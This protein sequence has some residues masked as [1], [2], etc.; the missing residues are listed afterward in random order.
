MEEGRRRRR[1]GRGRRGVRERRKW[2]REE[3][4]EGW[5]DGVRG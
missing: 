2:N 5:E 3:E 1:A 4:S